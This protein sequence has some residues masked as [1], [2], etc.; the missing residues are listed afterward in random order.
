MDTYRKARPNESDQIKQP[1]IISNSVDENQESENK[2]QLISSELDLLKKLIKNLKHD[3]RSPL[4][5]ISGMLDLMINEDK[6]QVEVQTSDLIII[7]EAAEAL[8]DLTNGALMIRD[9]QKNLKESVKND[10]NISSVITEM[11]RLYLPMAQNKSILLLL[12]S[13]IDEEI[14]LQHNF[15]INLIQI[16]G[17][18]V[19]NAVKFTPSEGSVD[20]V[21]F[22][23]A[24]EN[25]NLLNMTVTDTGKSISPDHVSAFNQGKPIPKSMGTNGEQGFGIGLRHIREMVSEYA[26]RIFVESR[27]GSGTTFSISF[28]IPGPD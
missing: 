22:L 26:G 21:F 6:E 25:N 18:L 5:G 10:R 13:Q 12:R 1:Q 23:D 19:A 24:D 3:I 17:N 8:L 15:F 27:E 16:T 11:N 20:V 14:Q 2:H 9:T 4:S 7:K 28:P